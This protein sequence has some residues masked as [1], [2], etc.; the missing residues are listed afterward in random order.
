MG[1]AGRDALRMGFGRTVMLESHGATISSDAN[2][3]AEVE[4]VPPFPLIAPI[5]PR[6]LI[7]YS[8]DHSL[9]YTAFRSINC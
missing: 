6:D 2:R 4:G 9:G 1:E 8:M 7:P 3:A 5:R